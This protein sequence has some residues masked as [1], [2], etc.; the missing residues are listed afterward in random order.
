[1]TRGRT[2]PHDVTRQ[3]MTDR[4]VELYLASDIG[5]TQ[6]PRTRAAEVVDLVRHLEVRA[7]RIYSSERELEA[8]LYATAAGGGVGI[9]TVLRE[10]IAAVLAAAPTA[11]PDPLYHL[12]Y[13]DTDVP[14]KPPA[15][16]A[17]DVV[18]RLGVSVY[19]LRDPRDQRVF[20][21]GKGRGNRIYSYV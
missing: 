9:P 20:Y 8:D 21:V 15:P 5:S 3:L 6:D 13:L 19:A 4:A 14:A 10:V 16:L 7:G 11:E 18:A 1:M 17:P 2:I 12:E